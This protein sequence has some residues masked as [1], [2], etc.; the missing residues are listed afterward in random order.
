[1]DKE[2]ADKKTA[3]VRWFELHFRLSTLAVDTAK[4]DSIAVFNK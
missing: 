2:E 3:P 1:M 4:A